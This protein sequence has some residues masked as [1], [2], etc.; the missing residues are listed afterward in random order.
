MANLKIGSKG[1]LLVG[2]DKYAY[3]VV[4]MVN[5]KTA[6]AVHINNDGTF[7]LAE[8]NTPRDLWIKVLRQKKDGSWCDKGGCS[9]VEGKAI[10]YLDPSF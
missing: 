1:T 2:S 5:E 6:I 3:E 10:N 8:K 9:F 4:E 7:W